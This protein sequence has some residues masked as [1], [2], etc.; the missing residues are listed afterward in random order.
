MLVRGDI[1]MNVRHGFYL[2]AGTAA[3]LLTWRHRS[4][5]RPVPCNAR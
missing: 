3:L 1:A 2:V 5:R 4:V